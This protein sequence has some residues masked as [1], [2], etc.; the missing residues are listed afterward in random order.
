MRAGPR[1]LVVPCLVALASTAAACGET[2]KT[3][4]VGDKLEAKRIE[5]TVEKVDRRTPVP[6]SDI[7]GLSLPSSGHRL[8][9]VLVNVC[10]DYGAVVGQFD[11]ELETSTGEATPKYTARNYRESFQS[12][13]DDCE[14][15]WIVF[16]IP[17]E[18]RPTKVEFAFD[19]SGTNRNTQD[20]LTARFE[21][22]VE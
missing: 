18:S 15:G 1:T 20:N 3:G 2:R 14:R 10:N 21:W 12:V 11:F 22:K 19:E 7:T 8:V 13:R 5:V 9:G 17:E 4:S 6:R 16:E